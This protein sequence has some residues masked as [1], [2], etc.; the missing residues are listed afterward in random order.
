MR[1]KNLIA[2]N[3]FIRCKFHQ[4]ELDAAKAHDVKF[5]GSSRIEIVG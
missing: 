5:F 1:K 2:V 4:F 3:I